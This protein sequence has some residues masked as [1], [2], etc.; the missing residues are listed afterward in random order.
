MPLSLNK[1]YPVQE[2]EVGR[3]NSCQNGLTEK[4]IKASE[5]PIGMGLGK[6]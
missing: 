2:P 1:E 6:L 5:P 3:N 4:V